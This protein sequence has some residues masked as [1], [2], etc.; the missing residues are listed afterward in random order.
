MKRKEKGAAEAGGASERLVE[1]LQNVSFA[2][3]WIVRGPEPAAP[4][5]ELGV[6]NVETGRSSPLVKL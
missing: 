2:A 6:P 3:S 5:T 1:V 4:V